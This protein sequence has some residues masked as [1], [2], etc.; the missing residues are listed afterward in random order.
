MIRPFDTY[1]AM[2]GNKDS[3]V[4]RGIAPPGQPDRDQQMLQT[5]NKNG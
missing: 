2:R 4:E 5:L 3:R 1:K